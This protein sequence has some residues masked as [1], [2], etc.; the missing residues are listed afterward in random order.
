M[1]I[2]VY[3]IVFVLLSLVTHAIQ[4]RCASVGVYKVF[5]ECVCCTHGRVFVDEMSASN[6]IAHGIVERHRDGGD[7][8]GI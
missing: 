8:R 3:V 5:D 1:S 2:A 7:S 4:R 6:P